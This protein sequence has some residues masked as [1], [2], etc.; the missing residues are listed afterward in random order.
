MSADEKTDQNTD[1]ILLITKLLA[2]VIVP[3][4][5]VAFIMLY[6]FPNESGTL[7]AWPIKPTLGAMM[8]G[9]TYLGGVYFFARVVFA[10]EWHTVKLG[11]LP[12][13][14]FAGILGISTILHWDKF[15]H[16]HISFL[17]WAFLYFTLP[18]VIP[19]VW[20]INRRASPKS[21]IEAEPK[22]TSLL[23]WAFGVVGAVLT[24]ASLILLI[25][26]QVMIPYW[27]WTVTEL[28]AR[29]CSAMFALSGLV[30]VGVAIEGRWSSAKIIF[31]AQCVSILLMLLAIGIE[32]MEYHWSSWGAITFVAGMLLVLL[33]IAWAAVGARKSL[34]KAAASHFQT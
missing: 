9:A 20:H 17:L 29:V 14:A 1:R 3:I 34:A 6:L 15:T 2:A 10:R 8:L 26:P 22:F 4:L 7:F 25:S 32:P 31:Q 5:F 13:S 18:F 11:F 21:K 33:L 27:P 28:T 16:G 30:G 23:R 24:F 12:V 19:V